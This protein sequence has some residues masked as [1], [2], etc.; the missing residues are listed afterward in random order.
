LTF[1]GGFS[2]FM[3]PLADAIANS[4]ETAIIG[5]KEVMSPRVNELICPEKTFLFE[6][7]IHHYGQHPRR[8]MRM[9]ALCR[10][11]DD[12]ERNNTIAVCRT[13][14]IGTVYSEPLTTLYWHFSRVRNQIKPVLTCCGQH[15]HWA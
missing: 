11:N 10:K 15:L 6:V 9:C 8:N 12:E 2:D 13:D 4:C 5:H 14:V 3:Y 1:P 7:L